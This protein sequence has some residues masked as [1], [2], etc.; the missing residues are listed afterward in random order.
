MPRDPNERPV[1]PHILERRAEKVASAASA[2]KSIEQ[3]VSRPKKT[4]T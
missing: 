4:K 1:K 2:T 3:S